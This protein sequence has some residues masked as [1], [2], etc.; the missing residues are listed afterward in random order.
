MN[1]NKKNVRQ[2]DW[3]VMKE[4]E[5]FINDVLLTNINKKNTWL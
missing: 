4:Q 3:F 5:I 1:K 2:E